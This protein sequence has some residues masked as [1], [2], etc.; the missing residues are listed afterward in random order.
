MYTPFSVK[1]VSISS[2]FTMLILWGVPVYVILSSNQVLIPQNDNSY[3]L[4]IK[5][6]WNYTLD[7][8]FVHHEFLNLLN[9]FAILKSYVIKDEH[10]IKYILTISQIDKNEKKIFTYTAI[11][12]NKLKKLDFLDF[13]DFYETLL[14]RDYEYIATHQFYGFRVLF[15]TESI[16]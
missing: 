4:L 2:A 6:D 1:N 15:Y 8:M 12:I 9:L 13:C 7:I 16:Y 11:S 10:A 14:E 5:G 3:F